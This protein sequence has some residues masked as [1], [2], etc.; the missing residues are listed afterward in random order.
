L[1]ACSRGRPIRAPFVVDPALGPFAD[2]RQRVLERAPFFGELVF[3]ADRRFRH[4]DAGDDALGLELAQALGQ[5]AV[6]DVGNG[7]AQLG[8]PHPPVKE[9]L[10]DGAGPAPADELDGPVELRAQMGLQTH[11]RSLPECG[12]LTQSTYFYIV[13]KLS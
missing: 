5:H 8:E 13:A 7:R 6:A 1:A 9:E 10:D 12:Y 11:A 4:D 2:R 3:D